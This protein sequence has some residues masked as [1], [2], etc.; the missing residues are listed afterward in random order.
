MSM[1]KFKSWFI[2]EDA[3]GSAPAPKPG[4]VVPAI[5]EQK[6]GLPGKP[7]PIPANDNLPDTS[8]RAGQVSDRFSKVLFKAMEAA[9]QPGFDYLEF[10]KALENL[11]KVAMDESTRYQSAYA[12]AQAMNITPQQLI[13]S[14]GHYLNALE[15]EENK[16]NSALNGQ[17]Q[18]QVADQKAIL[19][20]LEQRVKEL[21]LQIQELQKEIAATK[22]QQDKTR[23]TILDATGK[24]NTTKS[25]FEATYRMIRGQ[26]EKDVANMKTYL[27]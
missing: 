14:A 9:D 13:A 15:V 20:K 3:S 7:A 16:F 27:G 11:K 12:V 5:P 25:D 10:K 2:E 23:A 24:L 19:P 21:E 6:K 18:S 4:K 26:I 22:Q 8:N 1:K 17:V